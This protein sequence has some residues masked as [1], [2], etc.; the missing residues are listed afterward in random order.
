MYMMK[1]PAFGSP[2][3]SMQ[4]SGLMRLLITQMSVVLVTLQKFK[5]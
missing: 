2:L 4:Q 1:A 3:P 5:D